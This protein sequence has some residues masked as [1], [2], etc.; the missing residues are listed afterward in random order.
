MFSIAK[1]QAKTFTVVIQDLN[2][3]L[4]EEVTLGGISFNKWNEI[5]MTVPKRTAPKM[6]NPKKPDQYID[7]VNKQAQLDL[8]DERKRMAMRLAYALDVGG[9]MDWGGLPDD[10][11]LDEKADALMT[12]DSDIYQALV[13]ALTTWVFGKK[14]SAKQVEEQFPDVSSNGHAGVPSEAVD[15]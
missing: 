10:A 7:D 9:Q 11:D 5:G 2:D 14:V 6:K 15:D 8:E 4:I 13:N 3:N 1:H 12:L